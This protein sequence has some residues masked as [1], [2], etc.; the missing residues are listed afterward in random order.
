MHY[1][2]NLLLLALLSW[3]VYVVSTRSKMNLKNFLKGI[4]NALKAEGKKIHYCIGN[5]AADADSIVSALCYSYFRHL[6]A[7]DYEIVYCPLVCIPQRD[8]KLRRDV[9]V[10]LQ[11]VDLS[12][13]NLISYEKCWVDGAP[14]GD[15]TFSLTD[16]NALSTKI[17]EAVGR[18][19]ASIKV[20]D[21]LDH[22][23]DMEMH[24]EC[25]GPHRNIA[26][27]Y[28][29]CR[30][31]V[32][33][34][35]TL[36]YEIFSQHQKDA[37]Q[38]S[39]LSGV[40]MG[41]IALD[42]FSMD[43][44]IAKGTPRDA[45]ALDDLAK[46]SALSREILFEELKNAKLDVTFW[47]SL[48]ASDCFRLDY[49]QYTDKKETEI[50]NYGV[51]SVLL[52]VNEILDK[53]DVISSVQRYLDEPMDMLIALSFVD[54]PEPRRDMVVFTKSSKLLKDLEEFLEGMDDSPFKVM[55]SNKEVEEHALGVGI[56]I[57]SLIVT[58]VKLSRKQLAPYLSK[59]FTS[60]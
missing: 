5:E 26:F 36:I 59:F 30:P 19:G 54:K 14:S 53:A 16:H 48:S 21:I 34:A 29:F 2:Y 10:L 42:T 46:I 7:T 38:D 32:G 52:S 17:I 51:S 39:A 43:P 27:N 6:T 44:T 58:D 15:V 9:E 24:Q 33:S 13:D 25:Q 56:E 1:S 12:Y 37:L 41:V 35:C 47:R 18:D 57:L 22:H 3:K 23:A 49:K 60:K 4:P 55:E 50:F 20:T 11:R 31:E 8:L 45:T 28:E 40:L